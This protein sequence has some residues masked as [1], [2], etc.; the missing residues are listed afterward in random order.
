[1]K[2]GVLSTVL[3]LASLVD[4][5]P[6]MA[7]EP[8]KVGAPAPLFTAKTHSGQTFDLQSRK[9]QWTVLFFYPKA[10]TPGCTKQA[11]AFRDSV[12]KI[13]KQGADVFGVSADTVE[14]QAAFH[15]KYKMKFDLLADPDAKIIGLYGTKMPVLKVSKRWTFIIDPELKVRSI[16]KDVEPLLDAQKVSEEIAQ[17][18]TKS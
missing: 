12:D 15:T 16:R 17:L 7:G 6:A 9:G 18:Q 5:K 8:L 4:F 2:K 14:A 11:C 3:T 1:M 10:D 13:R